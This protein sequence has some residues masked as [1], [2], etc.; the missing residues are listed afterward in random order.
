M[1]GRPLVLLDPWPRRRAMIFTA[2]QWEGLTGLAEIAT[3]EAEG[4]VSASLVE[5]VLPR[6]VAVLGQTDLPAER[7]A[8]APRLRAV[9]NLEG[10]FLQN[11]DYDACL[12]RGIPVLSI[13]PVFSLPVAE[14]ALGMA[15]D[16][17]RGITAGD[18]AF[19]AGR[20][21]Y[22][23]LG[24]RDS[25][26]LTGATI[27]ILGLGNIGRAL[28]RLLEPFHARVLVHDP[29]LPDGAIRA[30]HAEPV[31]LEALLAES[32]VLFLLAAVTTENQGVLDR[33]RLERIRP[34]AAVVL[35]S[36]AGIVDFGA[37]V[38]L[39]EA[40]HF[41]AATDVFPVEPVPSD[42]PVRR[43]PLL[44]SAHRA[45]GIPAAFHAIGESV[46]DDLSL[47]LRGLPP[48]R[49]QA[50]RR[51]TVARFRSPPGRSY[52]KDPPG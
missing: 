7:L 48:V 19:R 15:L 51:E 44:L 45:G 9:V 2:A 29:W 5:G 11:V 38:A 26:L 14:M 25:F 16:L 1:S 35:A 30:E 12:A 13:A 50:A 31:G 33:S 21:E 20:E 23:F 28:R 34:G 32:Q 27:G 46:I 3:E 4:R 42:D 52:A 49:L 18:R 24:N 8:R 43:A 22:G 6:V 41:R 17:A 37:F 10:N 40:G 36:R 39:A 47:I